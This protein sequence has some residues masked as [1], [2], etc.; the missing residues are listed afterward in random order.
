MN[1]R[2]KIS[3]IAVA[4]SWICLLAAIPAAGDDIE[5]LSSSAGDRIPSILATS[6][7]QQETG[8]KKQV[9]V[10]PNRPDPDIILQGGDNIPTATPIPNLPFHGTGTTTGYTD[11]YDEMCPYGSSSPDVVYSYEASTDM[12]VYITLCNGSEYDTKLYV[13]ENEYTPGIPYACNDDACPDYVS[14]LID[15][16]FAAGNTYYIVIDGYGGQHGNYV[17]DIF[18]LLECVDC[19][20]GA[21]PEGEQE[22]H[23]DYED[24]TNGG[25]G[26]FPTVFGEVSC[27]ETICGE[28]GTFLYYGG[29]Y[30]DSDWYN[31]YLAEDRE[32]TI[33]AMA[34]FDMLV[35]II[36]MGPE[37]PC[38]GYQILYSEFVPVCEEYSFSV[39]LTAGGYWIWVAPEA[40]EGVPCGSPYYFTVT[41]GGQND[42][43][44]LSEWGMI[45]LALLLLV[46]GTVAVVR[47]KLRYASEWK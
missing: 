15:V 23:D 11:D 45:V 28:S 3:I 10:I 30:R 33:T 40:F 22:C 46:G 35:F 2:M 44:T 7:I 19:P 8:T 17:L 31:F 26:S 29:P 43:P 38:V 32:V 42:I 41:C 5:N 20:P 39:N 24:H 34:E 13:Y 21:T 16:F 27:G 18:E 47:K 4:F 36:E 9:S 1:R 12:S 25:C 14:K 37:I 6:N